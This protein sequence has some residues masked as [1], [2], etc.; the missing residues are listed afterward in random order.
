MN[1]LIE[2]GVQ[3]KTVE[4]NYLLAHLFRVQLWLYFMQKERLIYT[5]ISNGVFLAD[6]SREHASSS[7]TLS[8]QIHR[9]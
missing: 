7:K 1:M 3:F 4:N 6:A 8:L 2:P 9:L 5:E